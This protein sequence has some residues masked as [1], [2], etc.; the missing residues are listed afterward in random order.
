[1]ADT[2][3]YRRPNPITSA[4]AIVGGI[5]V[6]MFT[7]VFVFVGLAV[8]KFSDGMSELKA[9]LAGG[10]AKDFKY[11]AIDYK[12]P[13]IAG[14]KLEEEITSELAT[15]VIKK[16]DEAVE[17]ASVKGI[18]LEVNSPGG[19]VVASQEMY[20]A[21]K[22]AKTSKPVVAYYREV[23]ASGAYYSTVSSSKIVAN[24]GTMVGSIGVILS[25]MDASELL[26]WAK[27]K[28]VALKTGELKDTGSPTR[29]WS[30]KD[31]A[32]L[33]DL[34]N[35]TREQFVADVTSQRNLTPAAVETM[36]D[37]RV[38]LGPKA[39]ELQL[40]D[41][42]GSQADALNQFK[43]LLGLDKVPEL[44]WMEEPEEMPSLLRHLLESASSQLGSAMGREVVEQ[45]ER[46]TVQESQRKP[47]PMAK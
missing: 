21:I 33:Q 9:G 35:Q 29:P 5:T 27:L 4:L 17:H 8:F 38:V 46:A 15:N 41:A 19:S 2:S 14:I 30:E 10:S 45:L 37:G 31:K 13:L 1:M 39:L 44:E 25:T 6:L 16:I 24:R 34:I 26:G 43:D 20:D 18:F 40:V 3:P 12:T 47:I 7:L 42:L 32:Y 22:V 36:S 11:L 28:P 23:S